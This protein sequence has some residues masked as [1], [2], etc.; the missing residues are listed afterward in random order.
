MER[1]ALN[2]RVTVWRTTAFNMNDCNVACD[3]GG[4][5]GEGMC[6]D[7]VLKWESGEANKRISTYVQEGF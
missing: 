4:R 5:A 6:I 7:G 3:G 1:I 2:E